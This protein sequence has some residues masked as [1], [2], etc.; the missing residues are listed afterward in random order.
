MSFEFF[1]I[2]IAG[3]GAGVVTGLVGASAVV[4]VTPILITVLGYEPYTAIGISLAT[5]IIASSI[6]AYTYNRHGNLKLKDGIYLAMASFTAAIIGSWVSSY[7]NP[8][9]LG[10]STGIVILLMG[11][12]FMRKPLD[13]RIKDFQEKFDLSFWQNKK[14]F[15]AMTFGTFIG[16]MTGI[17]GA[18]GGIMILMVLTF[19]YG[20]SVHLA[21]GTS[22]LIMTFNALAGSISHFIFEAHFPVMEVMVSG[23]GGLIGALMAAIF[24]NLISER[25]LSKII[26]LVFVILGIIS[27]FN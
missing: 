6:S 5:D 21:V 3:W 7:F 15:S 24:A 8:V 19:I 16:M 2:L 25:R 11:I 12:S 10:G 27:V 1:I 14:V 17:F 22:V 13:Q 20:F 23:A 4:I 9:F 18:G 26:G